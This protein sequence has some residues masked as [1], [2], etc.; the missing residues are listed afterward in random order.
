MG[1]GNVTILSELRNWQPSY[2]T[3]APHPSFHFSI[4][5]TKSTFLMM[6]VAH[7]SKTSE[8]TYVLSARFLKI[9]I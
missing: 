5:Q 7:A 8:Q 6:D 1:G 3:D 4:A 2:D 9:A